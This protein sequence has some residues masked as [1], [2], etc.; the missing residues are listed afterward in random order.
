M[1]STRRFYTGLAICFAIALLAS[2]FPNIAMWVGF[3]FAAYSVVA[4]DSIQTLGT[5]LA[6]NRERS[7]WTL[8][9]FVAGLLLATSFFSWSEYGGDVSFQRLTAKGFEQAPTDFTF[10][11]VAAPLFLLVLTRRAIPVSTTF[12][13]LSAF[14]ASMESIGNVISKSLSGYYLAF[15]CS[16]VL[17]L[18]TAD[19]TRSVMKGEAAKFWYPLQWL[20]SGMLWSVWVMQDAANVAIYLPR[21]LSGF[22]FCAFGTILAIALYALVHRR[23]GEIQEVLTEKCQTT[24]VRQATFINVVYAGILYYFK[25]V[26]PTPMSTTWVFIGLL[27]GRE[28]AMRLR[29]DSDRSWKIVAKLVW[30]DLTKVALGLGVS[31]LLALLINPAVRQEVAEL[32]HTIPVAVS[33]LAF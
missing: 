19:W 14:A 2:P 25:V 21:K 13:I 11:Q 30:K 7:T 24:D 23:G 26:S 20:T 12:L 18:V 3:T 28:I 32:L 5:F 33:Q 15:A 9:F 6:S 31:I 8:W 29:N 10:L 27:A 22:E 17:W 4:N 1:S 16:L